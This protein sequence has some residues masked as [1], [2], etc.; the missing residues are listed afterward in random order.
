MKMQRS[1]LIVESQN[2]NTK[3]VGRSEPTL[4]LQVSVV[5][6]ILQS[7]A[8]RT[9]NNGCWM[10]YSHTLIFLFKEGQPISTLR[11]DCYVPLKSPKI[12]H[13]FA[14]E[15]DEPPRLALGLRDMDNAAVVG[16]NST[17]IMAAGSSCCSSSCV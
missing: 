17:Y 11:S 5:E 4:L 16:R 10:E 7:A 9:Y 1:L 8:I 12:K 6:R 2:W 14:H 13:H 15:I 3:G